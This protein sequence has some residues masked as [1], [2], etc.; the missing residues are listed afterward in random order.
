MKLAALAFSNSTMIKTIEAPSID[1][2]SYKITN[3]NV[4]YFTFFSLSIFRVTVYNVSKLFPW[5]IELAKRYKIWHHNTSEACIHNCKIAAKFGRHDL[6]KIWLI[7]SKIANMKYEQSSH[8]MGKQMLKS[9][10]EHC[11]KIGDFQTSASILCC[12]WPIQNK[13]KSLVP[14]VQSSPTHDSNELG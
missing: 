13:I 14:S 5:N 3:K 6:V 8:P 11:I 2:T 1:G 10:L 4:L 12:F 9:I 7:C